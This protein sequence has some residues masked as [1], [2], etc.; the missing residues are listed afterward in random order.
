MNE[1]VVFVYGTLLRG[2]PNNDALRT[3]TFLCEA[4]T[5][6]FGF[7]MVSFGQYPAVYRPGAGGFLDGTVAVGPVIG[8]LFSVDR[9]T[10]T[11]LDE[12]EGHPGFYSREL[13]AVIGGRNNW[14]WMYVLPE[15]QARQRSSV[16]VSGLDWRKRCSP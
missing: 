8:E 3:A 6:S 14:A 2:E 15:Q 5:K 16:N 1:H 9:E 4:R 12:I 10:L 7:A 13:V 11:L